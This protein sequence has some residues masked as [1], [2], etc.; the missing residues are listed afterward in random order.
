MTRTAAG[1]R[2]PQTAPTVDPK[3]TENTAQVVEEGQEEEENGENGEK[4][5]ETGPRTTAPVC[6]RRTRIPGHL[7]IRRPVLVSHPPRPHRSRPTRRLMP[8]P[9][10]LPGPSPSAIRI[11][12]PP[13]SRPARRMN[14]ARQSR[15]LVCEPVQMRP[16]MVHRP[17]V[18]E[19][20][21]PPL[22]PRR[23]C[24]RRPSTVI[25]LHTTCTN[26]RRLPRLRPCSRLLYPSRGSSASRCR[27]RRL[28]V[29]RHTRPGRR[30]PPRQRHAVP[31]RSSQHHSPRTP[32]AHLPHMPRLRWRRCRTQPLLEV[33]GVPVSRV[34]VWLMGEKGS[35]VIA[36]I[37]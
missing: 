13:P 24:R 3:N 37:L 9:K 6:N 23:T 17:P 25:R 35:F 10:T 8:I 12:R 26:R 34:R 22:P 31:S 7:R 20:P 21:R 5:E 19:C 29:D 15:P 16:C 2:L 27:I 28:S 32:T 30:S 11:R 36:L 1:N 33:L 4:E 18:L 14:L